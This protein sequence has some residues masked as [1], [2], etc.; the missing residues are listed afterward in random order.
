MLKAFALCVVFVGLLPARAAAEWHFT[1]LVGLTFKGATNIF[2]AE[3][4]ADNV[5]KNFGGAV[6]LLGDGIFGAEAIG[7]WMPSFFKADDAVDPIGG[8]PLEVEVDTARAVAFMG[9]VVLTTPRLWT[10][11]SLRPYLSGGAGLMHAK[12]T[13]ENSGSPQGA[14]LDLA[15]LNAPGFNVGVGAIGFFRGAI[16]F[17]LLQHLSAFGRPDCLRVRIRVSPLHDGVH[18]HRLAPPL[19]ARPPQRTAFSR[20]YSRRLSLVTHAIPILDF[21]PSFKFT[22]AGTPFDISAP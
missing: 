16:R 9:N 2:D 3:F 5:H 7:V 4:A 1:P 15:R 14:P 6:S 20:W 18:R 22:S 19:G 21:S 13:Q 17:P 8:G 10:E 12:V 11:Y